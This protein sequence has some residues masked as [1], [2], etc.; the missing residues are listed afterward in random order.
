M[1]GFT[2]MPKYC[3]I[4]KSS[5]DICEIERDKAGALVCFMVFKTKAAAL[6]RLGDPVYF[7]EGAADFDI[8]PLP[9]AIRAPFVY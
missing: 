9:A 1:R 8:V 2:I 3:I 7:P 4:H 6:A 5:G